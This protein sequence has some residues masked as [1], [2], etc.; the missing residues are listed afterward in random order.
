M[1]HAKKMNL[2]GNLHITT[3]QD[4]MKT[5][6]LKILITIFAS[7]AAF[8]FASVWC[9]E[10]S[11]NGMLVCGFIGFAAV[12]LLSQTAPAAVVFLSMVKDLFFG[13]SSEVSLPIMK[14]KN[15]K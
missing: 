7:I 14:S 8:A 9:V 2:I 11:G 6:L 10:Q 3:G 1:V 15:N 5:P 12:V 13:I 4:V